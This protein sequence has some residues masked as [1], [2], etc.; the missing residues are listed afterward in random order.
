[1][2]EIPAVTTKAHGLH[3]SV[4]SIVIGFGELGTWHF[5]CMGTMMLTAYQDSVTQLQNLLTEKN[6]ER[7]TLI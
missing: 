5:R 1:M 7:I 3:L 6:R 4:Y 2:K